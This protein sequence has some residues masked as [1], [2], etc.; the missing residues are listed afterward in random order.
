MI[1]GIRWREAEVLEVSDM[2]RKK[3]CNASEKYQWCV[4]GAHRSLLA[5]PGGC[6]GI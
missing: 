5:T 3:S 1:E 2:R 4:S 6:R